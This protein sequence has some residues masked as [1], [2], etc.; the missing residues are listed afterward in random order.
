M[1]ALEVLRCY[2]EGCGVVF[3]SGSSYLGHG[4]GAWPVE[5]VDCAA[6]AELR[7]CGW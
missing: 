2:C 6:H 5:P 7:H 1:V 3:V 4:V